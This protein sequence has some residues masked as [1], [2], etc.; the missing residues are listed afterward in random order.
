MLPTYNVIGVEHQT[1]CAAGKCFEHVGEGGGQ[2]HLHGDPFGEGCLYSAKNY[3][4]L[5]VHPPLT[6]WS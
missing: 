3:T 2:P 4:T 1:E 6:G 5:D